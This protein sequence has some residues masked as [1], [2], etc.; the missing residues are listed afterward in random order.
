MDN[1]ASEE[2]G[3][4]PQNEKLDELGSKLKGTGSFSDRNI[5][6]KSPG[7]ISSKDMIFRADKIDLKS[8]DV[9]L[10][11]HFSR[12]LSRNLENQNHVPQEDWE[13][14][15]SKLEIRYLVAQGTYGT[16]YRA[17]YDSKDVAVKL[18]D[19]G[20]DG[21]STA[22]ETATLRASF[23][24][25]V[26]VWHKLDHPNVTKFI[27][28][29]MGTSNLKIPSKNPSEGY[30]TIPSRACC[31][32]VEFLPGGTLKKFLYKNRK[33]K[34]AFK[35]VIQLALDLS[36]GL[37]YLHSKKIVHRDVK[38]ENMLLDTDRTLKIA[39]FGVARV[40][41]QNPKD[42][43][44]ETGT[45]GYMAPEVLDGKP[46]NRK[47][48]VYSFGICLWETY[49]CDLPY[50]DLSFAEVSSA[51]VRQNL[52]PEVP[53]CCPSSLAS[54]M[55]K[56]WDANPQKRPEMDEVVSLLEAID[57]TKGGGML[58]EDQAGGCFCFRPTRGP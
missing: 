7:S 50:P 13:I 32:V 23:R 15:P 10:E 21:M 52:R 48:D 57:T 17:T 54:I 27:G 43:T 26:A 37:C 38:A 45:L 28:A 55:K 2:G 41:A 8:L 9:H 29:S 49:C 31:V 12:V 4:M 42:M 25:E 46:Y 30:T 6:A 16:V 44:G 14:D 35:I 40:E 24:Q 18:L 39:D 47:C 58:P 5:A 20:E 11:K 51:V 19:W 1:K 3:V 53:R 34:L 33:K 22:A 36:R 56:C